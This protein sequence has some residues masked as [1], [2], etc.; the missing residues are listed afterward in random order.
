MAVPG[1]EAVDCEISDFCPNGVYLAYAAA[2]NLKLVI[3]PLVGSTVTVEFVQTPGQFAEH[4]SL[5]GKV[6]HVST[7]GIGLYA[8][9]IPANALQALQ[10]AA[11]TVP[12]L[13]PSSPELKPDELQSIRQACSDELQSFL[14]EVFKDFYLNVLEALTKARE[15]AGFM[16]HAQFQDGI[17]LLKGNRDPVQAAFK[18][19]INR[20][21]ESVE[22]GSGKPVAAA[23][24]ASL[25]LVDE[26]SFE[27][28]LALSA[29]IHKVELEINLPLAKFERRYGRITATSID[30]SNNPYAPEA[31]SRSLESALRGLDFSD[32]VRAI[33]Y[34]T[35]GEI[36]AGL[37]PSFYE[38]LNQIVAPVLTQEQEHR[39][40]AVGAT[41][42]DTG[43]PALHA[44]S[45]SLRLQTEMNALADKLLRLYGAAKGGA[46]GPDASPEYHL[47]HLLTAASQFPAG[48][49]RSAP[50]DA[51]ASVRSSA[52]SDLNLSR[53]TN[54]LSET[55]R[56]LPLHRSVPSL[57]SELALIWQ[58][59]YPA[60]GP[61][62]E[63]LSI[64]DSLPVPLAANVSGSGVSIPDAIDSQLS[65]L[66]A[67]P[68]APYQRQ[69]LDTIGTLLNQASGEYTPA[70]ELDRLIKSLQRPLIRMALTDPAFLREESH[71]ARE[72][73]NLLDEYAI[74]AD[75]NG[76]FFDT[77]LYN[78][79]SLLVERI[80]TRADQDPAIFGLAL[81]HLAR[82][83]PPI[84]QSR[85]QRVVMHQQASEGKNRIR[86][87]R[88]RTYE[89]LEDRLTNREVPAIVLRLL[90]LGWRQ[91]L[92][93]LHMR[94]GE[95][96][97]GWR[98]AL[99]ILA[100]L[101]DWLMPGFVADDDFTLK[102]TALMQTVERKLAG[103]ST[104]PQRLGAF[105]DELGELL[106]RP[107][108]DTPIA[109][110]KVEPGK[111]GRAEPVDPVSQ[112]QDA[113]MVGRLVIGD[114]WQ[115]PIKGAEKP[116]Q[117][118]WLSDP[119]QFCTFTNRSATRKEELPLADLE[120]Y[121]RAGTAHIVAD[122]GV[123]LFERTELAV[124]DDVFQ[125]LA[126]QVNH[127]PVTGLVNR[128]G[129][130]QRLQQESVAGREGLLHTVAVIEFDQFR[131]VYANCGV[132]AGDELT[133]S[134]CTE[135]QALLRPGDVLSSFQN[136]TFG[137]LLP[138]QDRAMG[139]AMANHLL[140]RLK[141]YR[142]HH[143]TIQYNIGVN[144]GIAEYAPGLDAPSD[145]LL[146][147][148]AACQTAKSI[149][150]NRVEAYAATDTRHTAQESLQGW[151]SRI[152]KL[153]EGDG[154]YLRCQQVSPTFDDSGLP[155]YF[156]ILLGVRDEAGAEV[157]PLQ[158]ITAVERWNRS[159]DIDMW[160][161]RQVFGWIRAN[162]PA[163]DRTGGF[164]VNLSS[165]SLSHPDILAFLHGELAKAD[166]P[167]GMISFE[168]TETATINNFSAAQDFIRQIRRY[169]CKFALDDFGSGYASYSNLKN[170]HT[171]TLKI[172]GAFVGEMD[173]NPAD[174]AMVK[175][176]NE[177]GHSLG[178]K[179]VAEFVATP[180]IL[181]KLR[182]IGVDYVQG[183]V[184][185]KPMPIDQ[186][187]P[188]P[189]RP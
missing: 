107:K 180:G 159:F 28:W 74:A 57:A 89:V 115:L 14:D 56:Q 135:I 58:D 168:I 119:P 146:H 81:D 59:R 109:R 183:Y 173:Q 108:T 111:P 32:P 117:L 69:A 16:Q 110:I 2:T 156:E 182:E 126:R 88:T 152:D 47:D 99:D 80:A 72:V 132:E 127:D 75:D 147:V 98:E 66:G 100:Q 145:I 67:G 93:L 175:S 12:N 121:I 82:L 178:M 133:R 105:L 102:A 128:K 41:L 29:E 158:F 170:L 22:K 144:I 79:L 8:A 184:I 63:L 83:L 38:R 164:S 154:L 169:G 10:R 25:S 60:T 1:E 114:W 53:I 26:N 21:I 106:L 48:Y 52:A 150:R 87:A 35:L 101:M 120:S 129:F 148:D 4:Y 95:D 138:K 44:D 149:G 77:R 177:I 64:L 167:A 76:K 189:E 84:K 143:G 176:M 40:R 125:G 71:P 141:E 94:Q 91:Y 3:P 39:A 104:E 17:E 73:V 179:T 55:Y 46:T 187:L 19:E 122:K 65:R 155:S 151:A 130:M 188:V 37:M 134:L 70:S 5:V 137:L 42:A 6:A 116:L 124:L 15:M 96:G 62:T 181:D 90:D 161:L 11:D 54:W 166:M 78:F 139:L 34:K 142:F 163:F 113:G 24:T 171:D 49:G 123:P 153:I 31:I 131:L 118:I 103:V 27:N 185:H 36:L 18:A 23:N 50:L 186:L 7:A 61:Q 13:A 85:R 43:G 165:Q 174:Y 160:V 92:T 97:V 86:V 33:I 30:R 20:D 162:R 51:E 9:T 157:S 112:G 68:I 136:D 45:E 172:D 140:Q